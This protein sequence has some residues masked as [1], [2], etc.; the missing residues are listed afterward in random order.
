MKK[1]TGKTMKFKRIFILCLI[2]LLF[3]VVNVTASDLND[4][5]M[6]SDGEVQILE[7]VNETVI[8]STGNEV[9]TEDDGTFSAL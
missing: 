3:G 2:I 8:E 1:I 6:A 4:T 7:Q 5:V 9:L